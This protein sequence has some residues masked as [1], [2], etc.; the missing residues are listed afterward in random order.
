MRLIPLYATVLFL[1]AMAASR[2]PNA[3]QANIRSVWANLF[4]V[5]NFLPLSKQFAPWTWSLAVEE[6]FY[7]LFPLLLIFVYKMRSR[8]LWVFVGFLAAAFVVRGWVSHTHGI[9]LPHRNP[10]VDREVGV[11]YFE[12]MH[13]N[14]HT[15]FGNIVAG[16][17]VA[18]LTRYT[19]LADWLR[20]R[21]GWQAFALGFGL[22]CSGVGFLIPAYEPFSQWSHTSNVLYFACQE[23][24]FAIG[25]GIVIFMLV[26]KMSLIR[27]LEKLFSWRLFYPI[28]QVSY[29]GYLVHPVVTFGFFSKGNLFTEPISIKLLTSFLFIFG[30]SFVISVIMFLA[31]EKPMMNLRPR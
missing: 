9:S 31:I 1:I 29:C 25:I 30:V 7:I 23:N 5:N 17:I 19:R 11:Q 12:K 28:A 10:A 13:S 24:V 14:L 6:Q 27:P 3:A 2:S 21:R 16:V 20:E 15:R 4:Y 22:L 18:Y 8:R 26:S